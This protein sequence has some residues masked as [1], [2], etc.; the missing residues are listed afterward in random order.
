M[1]LSPGLRYLGLIELM[2]AT[3]ESIYEKLCVTFFAVK[4]MSL[5]GVRYFWANE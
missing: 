4:L 3:Y 5:G 1:I 2:K